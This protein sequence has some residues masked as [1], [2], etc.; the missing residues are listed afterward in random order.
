MLEQAIK[1]DPKFAL[2]YV[3]VG[4]VCSAILEFRDQNPAWLVVRVALRRPGA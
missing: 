4:W 1:L 3:G 2:A